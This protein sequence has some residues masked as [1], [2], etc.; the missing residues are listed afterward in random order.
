MSEYLTI[1]EVARLA[2]C[3]HKSVRR[4]IKAGRLAAFR[5]EKRWV[6]A[7]EDAHA[8]IRSRPVPTDRAVRAVDPGESRATKRRRAAEPPGSVA[9][10]Q[11]M[12][13]RAS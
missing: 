4:A 7:E 10:L 11:A 8:W 13:R 9:A 1:P 5:G 6:I 12:E 2:R 3:E